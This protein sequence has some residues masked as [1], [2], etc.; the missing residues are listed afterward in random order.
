[1]EGVKRGIVPEV[2]RSQRVQAKKEGKEVDVNLLI[3]K[4]NHHP[5]KS[6]WKRLCSNLL[7]IGH[8]IA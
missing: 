1:V 4:I 2:Q 6:S 7:I 5:L 8:Q 3:K